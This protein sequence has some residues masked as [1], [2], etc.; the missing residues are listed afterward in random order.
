MNKLL[1]LACVAL[2]SGCSFIPEYFRPAAPVPE[3]WPV[4][5]G[6]GGTAASADWRAYFAD[7]SLQT[8]IAAALEHNRDLR[9]AVARVDE[10]RALAAA[11]CKMSLGAWLRMENPERR[12]AVAVLCQAP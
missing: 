7:A 1:S 9:V 5:V 12:M 11:P 3:Q 8:A 4:K 6:A 2:L 10:A